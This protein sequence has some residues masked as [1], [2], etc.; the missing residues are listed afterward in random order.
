MVLVSG[1]KIIQKCVNAW[2]DGYPTNYASS[3]YSCD[4][5]SLSSL[6][7]TLTTVFTI[8]GI[9]IFG[10]ICYCIWHTQNK[11][12]RV[13]GVSTAVAA[14]IPAANSNVSVAPTPINKQPQAGVIMM[15]QPATNVQYINQYGMYTY[16]IY[17]YIIAASYKQI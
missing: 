4:D 16:I 8:F 6:S 5:S 9:I 14:T 7:A 13:N 2:V 1:M 17:L 11:R 12:R 10:C 3:S 15:Q